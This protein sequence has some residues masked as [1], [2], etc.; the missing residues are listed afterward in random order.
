VFDRYRLLGLRGERKPEQVNWDSI[1]SAQ[2]EITQWA[3]KQFPKRTRQ[4]VFI[5]LLEEIAELAANPRSS[6]EYADLLVLIFDYASMHNIDIPN[7]LSVKM[8]INQNRKWQW[9]E[10]TGLAHHIEDDT[11]GN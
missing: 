7:A 8:K 6:T 10:S 4:G 2:T 9:D 11:H 5:K 3:D 1:K